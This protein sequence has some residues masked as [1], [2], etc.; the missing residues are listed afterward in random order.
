MIEYYIILFIHLLTDFGIITLFIAIRVESFESVYPDLWQN[1]KISF[2]ES[3]IV[4]NHIY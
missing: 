2:C 3:K 4:C 1:F